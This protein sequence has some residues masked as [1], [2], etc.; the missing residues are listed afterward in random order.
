MANNEIKINHSI[1]YNRITIE[2]KHH[3]HIQTS[4]TH[5]MVCDMFVIY[6]HIVDVHMRWN[7][8]NDKDRHQHTLRWFKTRTPHPLTPLANAV[9]YYF[10]VTFVIRTIHVHTPSM[11]GTMHWFY[12]SS[13]H[14]IFTTE[15]HVSCT[16]YCYAH[17]LAKTQTRTDKLRLCGRKNNH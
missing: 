7:E 4:T 12:V 6:C 13:R 2:V 5:F 17:P 11:A 9:R 8:E 1:S 14:S 16:W 15:H 3:Q 10:R